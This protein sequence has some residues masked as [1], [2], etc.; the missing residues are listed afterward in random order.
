MSSSFT[1]AEIKKSIKQHNKDLDNDIKIK[2]KDNKIF[3]SS[4]KAESMLLQERMKNPPKKVK[5]TP[6]KTGDTKG[7]QKISNMFNKK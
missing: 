3:F 4:T 2:I 7:Q 1:L 5:N 6:K